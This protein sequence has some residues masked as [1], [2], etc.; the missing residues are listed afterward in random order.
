MIYTS[1]PAPPVPQL[2]LLSL[3]F[4]SQYC[5]AAEDTVL[6]TDAANPSNGITKAAARILTRRIASALRELGIGKHGS[7]KDV[8]VV[9]SAGQRMLPILFYAVIAAG[10]V[11][12]QASASFKPE[13]LA[14][15]IQQGSAKLCISC[16]ATK[17]LLV[18]AAQLSGVP[19]DRCLVLDSFQPRW[20]LHMLAD[21]SARNIVGETELD[22]ERVTS[23]EKLENSVICLLYS[24]GTTGPP[25]GVIMSH[26]N[27]VWSAFITGLRLRDHWEKEG[28]WDYRTLAHLPAAHIAGVQGY[29]VI[30]FYNGGTTYWM[31]KFDFMDFLKYNRALE[32]TTFFTVPPIYVLI[33][34]APFVTDQFRTLKAATGGAA[35]LGKELQISVSNKLGVFLAQTWGL[36]ETTGSVTG[37]DV[38]IEDT[39]GS[40]GPLLPHCKLRLVDDDGK[41]CPPNVP[42]EVLVHGP[43]V[44]K[45]YYNNPEANA[46]SFKD[47]YLCTGDIG[48]FKDGRLHI[49]DR[50]KEL[51]K[52]KGLQVAPAELEAVLID[53]PKILDAGVIGVYDENEATE[54]PRA[55]V[56][57]SE[58]APVSAKEIQ[59]FVKSR[60]ASHKQLRGGVVFVPA[61]PKSASGKI[62]RKDLREMAKSGPKAKL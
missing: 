10:G 40:V 21:P 47:G 9:V 27:L 4:D 53:H 16:P 17:P 49:V 52:Y 19:D 35:P 34:K 46:G 61:I 26:T 25:K 1:D 18:A 2:D 13:E 24:S 30:P 33:N 20:C 6:H 23:Q 58:Q 8:V 31:P 36:S 38:N 14:R 12:S 32:I 62:L 7:G 5:L 43:L 50:K 37:G 48:V 56:V 3:L 54:V 28:R 44:T 11:A 42:G 59:D 22:W 29:F 51:I 41:D 57:V 15:Q 60:L 39:S 55:Y 45:G